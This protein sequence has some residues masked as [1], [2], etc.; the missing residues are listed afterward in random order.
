MTGNC[1]YPGERIWTT[2]LL[3]FQ[4][5]STAWWCLDSTAVGRSRVFFGGPIT[6]LKNERRERVAR[7]N[8]RRSV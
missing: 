2:G 4:I 8:R 3:K 7:R 6:V 1:K 5:N